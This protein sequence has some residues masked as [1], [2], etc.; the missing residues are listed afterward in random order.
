MFQ[1]ENKKGLLIKLLNFLLNLMIV[2]FQHQIIL[3]LS[4]E[5]NLGKVIQRKIW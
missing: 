1:H 4:H 2:L 3:T 5:P